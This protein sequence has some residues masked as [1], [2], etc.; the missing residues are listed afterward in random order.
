MRL[1]ILAIALLTSLLASSGASARTPASPDF[2]PCADAT[3]ASLAGSLCATVQT[4]LRHDESS[5]G[6]I[7]LFVRRF[8]AV[9]VS[10]GDVWLIAGGPGESG[11]GFY[12]LIDRFRAAFPG[13]DLIVPDHRGTG[14][15]SR[16]CVEEEA[17]TSLGGRGLEGAEWSTCFAQLDARSPWVQSFTVTNA[18]HD[19]SDLIQQ[20]SADRQTYVYGVSYGTQ[21]VLRMMTVA[22]P[23]SVKGV[24]LD[25][26]V[27]PDGT[28]VWDLSHRSQVVD[29]VGREVLD[30]CD[31]APACRARLGG[32]AVAALQQI[33]DDPERAKLFPG[34]HPK[35]FL[36]GLLDSPDARALIPEVIAD[37]LAGK[38]DA[39]ERAQASL[40]AFTAPFASPEA[41]SSIPLVA[42]ISASENNARTALTRDDIAV[43]ESALLFTS[44][45][46]SQLLGGADIT[47]PR[48]ASFGM[49]PTHMPPV[50]ILQ[51]DMD[52]KTPHAGAVAHAAALAASGDVR[53]F[54]I[55][56]APHFVVLTNP[57]RSIT[58]INAF[59][60][61]VGARR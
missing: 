45:L 55:E 48:D 14:R 57:G 36:G 53:L 1:T 12:G 7:D 56:G 2:V 19:L 46:P 28:D 59:V 23:A 39:I 15:S 18:A 4:P 58:A 35:A 3:S 27:P 11:A 49:I 13:Y 42:L 44:S 5:L 50:L 20:Y 30:Q 41:A 34:G 6:D 38:S 24:V 32:S 51:G 43:E 40:A 47:Y 22:P 52:P 61:E 17:P 16:V 10:R 29:S 8:P 26:L 31:L 25:S 60:T 9:G 33:V 37:A 21:L 54:T